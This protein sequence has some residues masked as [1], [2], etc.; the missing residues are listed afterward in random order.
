MIRLRF[1]SLLAVSALTACGGGPATT[2][3]PAAPKTLGGASFDSRSHT[4][5]FYDPNG[6]VLGTLSHSPN[7][8]VISSASGIRLYQPKLAW[9]RTPYTVTRFG[10]TATVTP[11][12]KSVST[13]TPSGTVTRL[14]QDV[15]CFGGPRGVG[16]DG[17]PLFP[18]DNPTNPLT[19]AP[20]PSATT[21]GDS[22]LELGIALGIGLAT[23]EGL[24]TAIIVL[25]IMYLLM[26]VPP[27]DQFLEDQ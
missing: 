24:M 3:T 21:I 11:S 7:A 16:S 15:C 12:T 2:T 26:T 8:Y 13:Q 5:T 19:N 6:A 10:V 4:A 20:L 17:G 25:G 18:P 22:L 14:M 23:P 9:T 1:G 27:P